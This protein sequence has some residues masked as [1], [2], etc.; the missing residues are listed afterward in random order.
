M[1]ALGVSSLHAVSIG[2]ALSFQLAL[3]DLRGTKNKR[4][5]RSPLSHGSAIIQRPRLEFLF[6][7]P[8]D[9]PF[10]DPSPK[11]SEH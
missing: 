1:R 8:V 7:F 10:P 2:F 9:A 6:D 3:N 4:E 5:M 11:S